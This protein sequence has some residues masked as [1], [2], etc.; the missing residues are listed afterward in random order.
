MSTLFVDRRGVSLEF[1]S[2]AIVFRE[3]GER[4]GTVPVAPLTRVFLRGD[5]TIKA[6]LLAQLGENGVGVVILSGR[7]GKPALMLGRPHNDASR[8]VTQIHRSLDASFCLEVAK[9]LIDRKLERQ[10]YW[11]EVLAER[12][13]MQRSSLLQ[14]LRLLMG[15]RQRIQRA[16]TVPQLRG[17]EGAAAVSYFDGLRHL[18]PESWG[19]RHRNRRP[20]RDPFN[21]ILSLSYTLA[22]A[23]IAIALFAAGLDPYVGF[24]HVV[25]YARES[26]ASDVLEAV[27]PVCDRFCLQLVKDEVLSPRDDFSVSKAGCLLGKAGRV[28][29]YRSYEEFGESLR[30][31]VQ[32]EIDWLIEMI[33]DKKPNLNECSDA[34]L[35]EAYS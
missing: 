10:I 28:R 13:P 1:Q 35:E 27:R 25:D 31:A 19:F 18:L 8:R 29:F 15:H 11:F 4:I 12:Y 20:P 32:S 24:Y 9:A 14:A 5:V 6:S 26:L 30:S 16:E 21:A 2:G 3:N 22:H 34:E 7:K 23:E 17:F 33:M